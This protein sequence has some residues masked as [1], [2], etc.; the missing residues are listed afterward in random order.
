VGIPNRCIMDD[1]HD[2]NEWVIYNIFHYDDVALRG[3]PRGKYHML[4]KNK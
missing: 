2:G 3:F 1:V 4:I